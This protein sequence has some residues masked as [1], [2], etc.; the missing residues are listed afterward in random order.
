MNERSCE[1]TLWNILSNCLAS[2]RKSLVGLGNVASEG[3]DS[4][5]M[6]IKI[7]YFGK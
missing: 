2:L 1:R 5:D 3:W 6:L 7:L 4:L